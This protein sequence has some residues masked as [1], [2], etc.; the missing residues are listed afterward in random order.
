VVSSDAVLAGV[1]DPRLVALSIVI[2]V[3]GSHAALD[4]AARVSTKRSREHAVWLAGGALAIGIGVWSVHYVGLTACRLPVPVLYDWPTSLAALTIAVAGAGVALFTTSRVRRVSWGATAIGVFIGAGLAGLHYLAMSSMRLPAMARYSPALVAASIV[5]AVVC[6]L[7][8]LWLTPLFRDE[9]GPRRRRKWGGAVL[10]AAAIC[11]VHYTAMAA[12]RFIPA[13]IGDTAHAVGISPVGAID[14]AL[15]VLMIL[16]LTVMTSVVDRL[17]DQKNALRASEER[18]RAAFADAEIGM[19]IT[20]LTGRFVTVNRAFCRLTGYTE[21]ELQALDWLAITHPDDRVRNLDLAERMYGGGLPTVVIDKRYVT[22]SGRTVWV[23]NSTS[24]LHGSTGQ[25]RNV[26]A[27][28]DDV[29]EQRHSDAVRQRAFAQLRALAA[30]LQGA[31]EE[32]RGRVAREI[33]DELG[34]ALTAIKL[35]LSACARDWPAGP[36]DDPAR[37][38]PILELVDGAIHTVRRI[39]T[40]L[41]PGI[42][43]D[44]G[45]VAAVEWATQ[46][47]QRRTGIVCTVRLPDAEVA[48]DPDRATA[49]FRILQETLTNVAR[50]ARATEVIV[51]LAHGDGAM[52]MTVEDNG[53]GITNEQLADSRSLGLLGMRERALLLGGE[54]VVHARPGAG[55]IVNVRIPEA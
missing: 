35:E 51:H 13:P 21:G 52:D 3:L 41:R 27:L 49:L 32:E 55:T 42:L 46:E 12:S 45:L 31:R 8:M 36:A 25:P 10:I 16:G 23:R 48:L 40:E 54:V 28:V 1:W 44:L 43:D 47:F 5:L 29:T 9:A 39:A 37:M 7:T 50:H 33:H 2:A 19:A 4:L 30:R 18:F 14:I 34:Q 11:S 6:A 53:V 15:I 24:L 17:A 38:D 20:D 26:I 22:K